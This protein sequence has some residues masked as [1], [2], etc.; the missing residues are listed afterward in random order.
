MLRQHAR[1][2]FDR[3]E[4][5]NAV[6]P[7]KVRGGI[8]IGLFFVG[9]LIAQR[10]QHHTK[11]EPP[12]LPAAAALEAPAEAARRQHLQSYPQKGAAAAA[13]AVVLPQTALALPPRPAA[14]TEWGYEHWDGRRAAGEHTSN[15]PVA[16][17][18]IPRALLKDW[19]L[20]SRLLV[21]CGC[22]GA[23]RPLFLAVP[24]NVHQPPG[25]SL[26]PRWHCRE[27]CF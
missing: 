10:A 3:Y 25:G 22:L 26:R 11:P 20:R 17:G 24:G 6:H 21:A 8:G 12:A 14:S 7:I 15:Q 13:S 2:T 19:V 5:L 16:V 1:R 9:D 27:D 18:A 23:N 4:T